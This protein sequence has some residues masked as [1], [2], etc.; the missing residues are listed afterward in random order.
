MSII[1]KLSKGW[2]A[3][4]GYVYACGAVACFVLVL[5]D[6]ERAWNHAISGICFSLGLGFFWHLQRGFMRDA[7]DL[8]KAQDILIKRQ[9]DLIQHMHKA[10]K[11]DYAGFVRQ[12]GVLAH[13]VSVSVN[14]SDRLQ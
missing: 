9:E 13:S 12:Y 5:L 4:I 8:V 11:E 10:A 2:T 6:P 7:D 14:G 3:T 1:K